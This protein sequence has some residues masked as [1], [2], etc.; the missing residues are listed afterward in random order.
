VLGHAP[1]FVASEEFARTTQHSALLFWQLPIC[2]VYYR[3]NYC[4]CPIDRSHL[5]T[6]FHLSLNNV[7][8]AMTGP[9][10]KRPG[11]ST[12][13]R[14]TRRASIMNDWRIVDRL[15]R[16]NV[17]EYSG[18]MVR[19]GTLHRSLRSMGR[20]A[21]C[22]CADNLHRRPSGRPWAPSLWG[23]KKWWFS[24]PWPGQILSHR[25]A[26]QA[27]GQMSGVMLQNRACKALHLQ[28]AYT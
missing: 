18:A 11:T 1:P 15:D 23:G 7:R 5:S 21:R 4:N 19:C 16:F 22:S 12:V 28:S 25:Y 26:R 2:T 9:R 10:T 20:V 13:A 3:C 17:E 27:S 14:C 8:Q 6:R 24:G